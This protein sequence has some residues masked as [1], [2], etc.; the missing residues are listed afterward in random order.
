MNLSDADDHA[1]QATPQTWLLMLEDLALKIPSSAEPASDH[2]NTR[3]A[4]IIRVAGF[5]A[6]ALSATL[7]LPP[8]PLGLLTVIP[9]LLQVWQLQQQMVA[10]V[11]ACFGKTAS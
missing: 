7:A 1:A 3:A 8:G 10:D 9:D 5:K 4:E 11:A 6:G 2:P